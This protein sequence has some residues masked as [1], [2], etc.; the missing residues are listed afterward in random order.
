MV[1]S[2]YD[3]LAAFDMLVKAVPGLSE[4]HLTDA[5]W[6]SQRTSV[7]RLVLPFDDADQIEQTLP[8]A[9]EA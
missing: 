5:V 2:V 3:R 8:F 7:R 4:A 6:S 9:V 1:P